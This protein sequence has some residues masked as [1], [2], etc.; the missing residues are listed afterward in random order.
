MNPDSQDE[1]IQQKD[2]K[3]EDFLN[4]SRA[5]GEHD[6][7]GGFTIS[8]EEAERKL[9]Q[10]TLPRE[11]AWV[12]KLVQASVAWWCSS[13]EVE[14]GALFTKLFLSFD[15]GA[16]LPQ[17]PELARAILTP[18]FAGEEPVT[19]MVAGLRALVQQAGLSFLLVATSGGA[20][21][22]PL[23]FGEYF[24]GI[25][26][27]NLKAMLDNKGPGVHVLVAQTSKLTVLRRVITSRR[28]SKIRKELQE[29]CYTSPVPIVHNGVLLNGHLKSL[30][31]T[32]GSQYWP[33][34]VRATDRLS[35]APEQTNPFLYFCQYNYELAAPLLDNLYSHKVDRLVPSAT[36]L[37]GV[38]VTSGR[39]ESTKPGY[40]SFVHWIRNGVV[41]ERF[42]LSTRTR[43]LVCSIYLSSTGLE[44]DLSGLQLLK[45]ELLYQREKEAI[46]SLS[47][48][49][50]GLSL[51]S[52][53]TNESEQ[54]HWLSLLVK[55]KA[56]IVTG[57]GLWSPRFIL[58]STN[59]E[60]RE[61]SED[62][63]YEVWN[64]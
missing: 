54:K 61:Q 34:A 46:E 58:D 28:N 50:A 4:Q 26:Q 22:P 27:S 2:E 42:A 35:L 30:A 3:L 9:S 47:S 33:I 51:A 62:D 49:L 18:T 10:F 17:V 23:C 53:A 31:P 8:R 64:E 25:K 41:I 16:P 21:S 55:E 24:E 60:H 57:T 39:N 15:N 45:N 12:T 7:E 32:A 38:Q 19:L 59:V 56:R 63:W 14:E 40:L 48:T 11:T 13:L 5:H 37:L 20:I 36:M 6:S 1:A 44:V 52:F 29:F 43:H